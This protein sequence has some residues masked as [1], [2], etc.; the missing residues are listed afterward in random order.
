MNFLLPELRLVMLDVV[1]ELI[2]MILL[3]IT[4]MLE[5]IRVLLLI[6]NVRFVLKVHTLQVRHLSVLNVQEGTTLLLRS[7]RL[8]QFAALVHTVLVQLRHVHRVHQ[9]SSQLLVLQLAAVLVQLEHIPQLEVQPVLL[10]PAENIL[11][12]EV[13]RV[14]I[15]PLVLIQRDQ[16]PLAHLVRREHTVGVLLPLVHHAHLDLFH[17]LVPLHVDTVMEENIPVLLA[18]LRALL[19]KLVLTPLL[20]PLL[21]THHVFPVLLVITRL[22]LEALA[23]LVALKA[24]TVLEELQVV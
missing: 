1:L 9:E 7:R 2:Y 4:V 23:V 17:H 5:I 18:L 21:V 16:Q 12:P 11:R 8:V 24:P 14:P 13:L 19:V 15:V 20:P 6:R 10:V 3:V 22:R